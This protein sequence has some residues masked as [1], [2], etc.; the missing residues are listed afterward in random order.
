MPTY[1]LIIL[2]IVG[3]GIGSVFYKIANDNVHP[4]MVSTIVTAVY[5]VLTPLPFMFMNFDRSVN[6]TG[7][8]FSILGGLAMCAGSMGYFYALRGGSAGQITTVTAVYPA[9]TLVLSCLFMGE[10]MSLK[11]GI[12][13]A[14]A[15]GSV[16]LLSQK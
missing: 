13:V 1:S 14:L 4:M 10:G 8:V 9:L 7:V 11:K 15:L 12:G 6:T 16:L 2:S 3:W 5:I